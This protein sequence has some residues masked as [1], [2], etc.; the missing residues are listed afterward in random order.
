MVALIIF[1]FLIAVLGAA[2]TPVLQ[3]QVNNWSANLTA[4]NQSSAATIVNLIPTIFW[5][6]LAVAVILF[7]VAALLPG[8]TA[9]L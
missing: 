7:A 9:G 8:K 4:N 5:I 1:I 6:L 3:G 2:F